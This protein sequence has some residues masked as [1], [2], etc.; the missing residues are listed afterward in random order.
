MCNSNK[1]YQ[2]GRLPDSDEGYSFK[3]YRFD[4]L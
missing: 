2:T 4:P 3:K 1:L